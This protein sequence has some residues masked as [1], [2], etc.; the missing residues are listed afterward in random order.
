MQR[1][2]QKN[3]NI[4]FVDAL[5]ELILLKFLVLCNRD[6]IVILPF[7]LI[8]CFSALSV[9]FCFLM[10]FGCSMRQ[11]DW[12]VQDVKYLQKIKTSRYFT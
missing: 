1:L 2:Y 3:L 11:T 10:N 4:H 6:P 8:L 12:G 7:K 5:C 9:C